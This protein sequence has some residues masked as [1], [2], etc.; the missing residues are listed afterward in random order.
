MCI[1]AVDLNHIH[2]NWFDVF[3][4]RRAMYVL[5]VGF[6]SRSAQ[7]IKS[8]KRFLAIIA[9]KYRQRT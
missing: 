5:L 8:A 3:G 9:I 2:R 4:V 6:S 7:K 1:S